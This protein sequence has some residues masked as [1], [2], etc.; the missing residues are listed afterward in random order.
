M[1]SE[2]GYSVFI[3][4]AAGFVLA[5]MAVTIALLADREDNQITQPVNS[6]DEC[7]AAGN[8]VAQSYPEQCHA[9]GKSFSNPRQMAPPAP[10]T[11]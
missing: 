8:P 10:E 6:F 3:V 11:Q 5:V 4:V 7:V 2:S 9:D 1:K